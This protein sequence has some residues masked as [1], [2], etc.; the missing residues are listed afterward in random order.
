MVVRGGNKNMLVSSRKRSKILARRVIEQ[1]N[2]RGEVEYV[3]ELFH[4]C[5]ITG[6]LEVVRNVKSF[7]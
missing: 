4:I 3:A 2:R 6:A 7:L 5:I 1:Y